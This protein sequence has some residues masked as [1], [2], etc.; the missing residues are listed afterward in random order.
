MATKILVLGGTF[1]IGRATLELL[2]QNNDY[3]I[4]LFN[5]GNT[6]AHLFPNLIRITGD[7]NDF[8]DL[9]KISKQ[10]WDVIIDF[11]CYYPKPLARLIQNL[12]GKV[13]RYIFISTA[14]VYDLMQLQNDNIIKEDFPL[15]SYT[16]AD[17]IDTSMATYGQRKVACEQVLLQHS[18]LDTIILRPSVVYGKYD[19]F[20]RHYYW[21]YR[22]KHRNKLLM[23]IGSENLSA[24]TFVNDLASI[25]DK[26]I[27][28]EQHQT[29]YNTNTHA[30]TPLYDIVKQMAAITQ[31]TPTFVEVPADFFT[32]HKISPWSDIALWINGNFMVQD[33][34]RLQNDFKLRLHTLPESLQLTTNYYEQLNWPIPK[35]GMSLEKE[36][37]LMELI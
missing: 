32:K 24:F 3:N 27:G 15:L 13:K 34:S 26:A 20:D 4:T 8:K 18:W 37:S 23:P 16:K 19:P 11:S 33:F 6:N 21:L 17:M 9:K 36:T 25:I 31:T 22:V 28:I 12:K 29:I 14:S 2:T 1:F 5:R 10:D 35:Y 7:R 30:P